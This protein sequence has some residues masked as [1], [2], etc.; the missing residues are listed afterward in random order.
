MLEKVRKYR[1]YNAK[2]PTSTKAIYVPKRKKA[3][4]ATD[5]VAG[6]QTRG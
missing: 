6:F 4:L 5:R 2:K 1:N 3:S